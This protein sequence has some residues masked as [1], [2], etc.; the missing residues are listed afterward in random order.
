MILFCQRKL[1]IAFLKTDLDWIC[2]KSTGKEFQNLS[3]NEL[4]ILAPM[5]EVESTTW[6][7]SF[8]L[9]LWW[10]TC[11]LVWKLLR[12]KLGRELQLKWSAWAYWSNLNWKS[13]SMGKVLHAIYKSIVWQYLSFPRTILR[14]RMFRIS[15]SWRLI[16]N[17][18]AYNSIA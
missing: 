10:W 5:L 1:R 15:R 17:V 4:V 9:V 8:A 11:L 3:A 18:L 13:R 12:T 16:L 6:K 2:F 7:S 14:I